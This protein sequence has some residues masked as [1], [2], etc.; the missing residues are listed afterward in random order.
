MGASVTSTTRM[1]WI[2]TDA[3]GIWHHSTLWRWVERM[4]AELHRRLGIT[5]LT[6]GWTPRR[7]LSAEFLRGI[8]F[9]D[10]VVLRLE[11]GRVGS[12]S[13]TYVFDASVDGE[14]AATA[15]LTCV[16][17]DDDGRPRPWPADARALLLGEEPVAS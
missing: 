10:E 17:V 8:A 2:D 9:D 16:L 13:A 12:T 6:F 1:E 14:V 3:A 11:V 7:S 15:E 4:E 5:E